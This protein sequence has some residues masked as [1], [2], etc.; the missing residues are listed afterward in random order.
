MKL[1]SYVEDVQACDAK[2]GFRH[3]AAYKATAKAPGG[4]WYG[5]QT[6]K[7]ASQQLLDK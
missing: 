5:I 4:K 7:A 1:A 6:K 3:K 2:F